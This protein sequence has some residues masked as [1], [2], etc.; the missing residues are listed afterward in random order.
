[1]TA[2]ALPLQVS[3]RRIELWSVLAV[4]GLTVVSMG[5]G[6]VVRST[7]QDD[8]RRIEQGGLSVD[9]PARWIV[10]TQAGD[11]LLSVRDP[12]DPDLRYVVERYDP[13]GLAVDDAARAR[14]TEQ[15]A[16]LEGYGLVEE[17]A[18]TI[19]GVAT[20]R[21]RYTFTDSA[22]SPPTVVEAVEDHFASGPQIVV[23]RLEAPQAG[24]EAALG[25]YERF[26]E[27]VAASLGKAVVR[28]PRTIASVGAG[29][30]VVARPGV[31]VAATRLAATTGEM[32]AA[33][34]EVQQLGID[35][36]PTSVVGLG[37]GTILSA[38]GLILTNAHVAMPSAAGLNI[39][40]HDPTPVRDPAGLVIAIVDS[41]DLPPVQRYR[42]RVVAADG[43]LD[44]AL[45][46]IDRN[47]DGSP[48]AP[49]QLHLP[50]IAL[51]DSDA[52]RVGDKLT[53]VGFP[54]IG[55]NTISLSSGEVSGFLG[56]DRIG[57]RAWLK[58]SAIVS[59]GNSGGLAADAEGRIVGIPTRG[60]EDVGGYS[61]V[62]PIT[63]LKPMIDAARAGSPSLDSRYVVP[64]TGRE[65][66]V[67]NTWAES[68]DGCTPASP[69]TSYP[70]GTRA[71]FAL[72][73]HAN[74][75]A[76]EDVVL[77]WRLDG[78][79]IVRSGSRISSDA[80]TGGCFTVFVYHD[81]GLPDGRYR[82][83]LFVGPKLVAAASAETTVGAASDASGASL[84]GRVVD[85]DSRQ[86]LS[87]AVVFALVE[88]TNPEAWFRAPSAD[89]IAA[90]ATTDASGRFQVDGLKAGSVYPVV[91]VADE[92]VA[93]GG[94]IGPLR[95]GQNNLSDDIT[96]VRS[97][98]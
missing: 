81:R 71:I 76:G 37:S 56:D 93:T 75:A 86:P 47:L 7:V 65:Q 24:F 68:V 27:Q 11:A 30:A 13:A 92:Y 73:T 48:I 15:T 52:L 5:L 28:G 1:M 59:H 83:D 53:V 60:R 26:R 10:A 44:A 69:K 3:R 78:D 64:A 66:M 51:G 25:R 74:M 79:V 8:T 70:G 89:K 63:L 21:L 95:P 40:D 43:Y 39:Y 50:T 98:P 49:G 22:S 14:L 34:V 29:L 36:D 2:A 82:V 35:N 67:F 17:G 97:G 19:G 80:A 54:G 85:V 45:I 23:V 87:G 20:H 31:P 77:Q 90:F 88:G 96:L 58:T 91:V 72:F 6:L 84:T 12:L 62:R 57:S 32:V 38:D 16:L 41:E 42:A 46:Q 33:T 18:G 55:G 4:I 9:I 94:T 61:L